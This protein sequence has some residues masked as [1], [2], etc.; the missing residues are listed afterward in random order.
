[1]ERENKRES[2]K[3]M[4]VERKRLIKMSEVAYKRDPRVKKY[5]E[6][7]EMERRERS[8]RSRIGKTRR[9]RKSKIK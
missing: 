5:K 8:R 2:D 9:E 4:K 6:E 3:M 7:E 1:M